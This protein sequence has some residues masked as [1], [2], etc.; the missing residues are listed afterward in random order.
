MMSEK[1]TVSVEN[2]NEYKGRSLAQETWRRFLKNKGA[3]VGMIFMVLLL[4]LAC[5]GDLLYDYNAEII[6]MNIPEASLAPSLEH[7][8]GTDQLGRD[9]FARVVYGTRYSLIIGVGSVA[10][11]LIVGLITGSLAG[12]YGGMWD[13]LVMRSN[14]ILYSIPNIMLAVV[15]VQVLGTSIISLVIALSISSATS[16]AKIT[17]AAVMTIQGQEYVESAYAMGLPAWKIILKHIIPNCLSPIIVQVTLAIGSNII[18]ASSLSFLGVGVPIPT[19]EW[20]TMLSDGRQ[21]IVSEPWMCVFPG[22][23]IMLTV[24]ALNLMGDGLRDALDPKLKR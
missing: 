21:F 18:A 8:F 15:I 14:D 10:V 9:V 11:G 16:F 19:P 3:V 12:F 17:R 24:L 1:K 7:L 5:A 2:L 4:V 6:N 23:A 22:L 20:G 13:Q